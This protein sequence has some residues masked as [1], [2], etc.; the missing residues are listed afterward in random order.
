MYHALS[1]LKFGI[2]FWYVARLVYAR[3]QVKT[4]SGS[5]L[6][7]EENELETLPESL[8]LLQTTSKLENISEQLRW[9]PWNWKWRVGDAIR[10]QP[11]KLADKVDP[12]KSTEAKHSTI[13]AKHST[14]KHT[15][16]EEHPQVK[17]VTDLEHSVLKKKE[18]TEAG[19]AEEIIP[20]VKINS[21]QWNPHVECHLAEFGGLTHCRQH[22]DSL[23]NRL[24]SGEAPYKFETR[25]F[26]FASIEY[27]GSA[28]H[29][30]PPHQWAKLTH[31]CSENGD[32]DDVTL[33]YNTKLW[34]PLDFHRGGCMGPA[35]KRMGGFT[36]PFIAHAFNSTVHED[37]IV[38]VVGA[39]FD[40]PVHF[41]PARLRAAM[42][43]AVNQGFMKVLVIADTNFA[44]VPFADETL[45]ESSDLLEDIGAPEVSKT[46][47][48]TGMITCCKETKPI[49]WF[50]TGYDRIMAN[51]GTKMVTEMGLN[52]SAAND[53]AA[54]YMH[55][56]IV[57]SLHVS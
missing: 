2:V 37:M 22:M 12:I 26:D 21:L 18:T 24:L 42:S 35:D 39:H 51:F 8:L 47:S 20:E 36:K 6:P 55:L 38:L 33:L 9:K 25:S 32:G 31:D 44:T 15:P 16:E 3:E 45:R 17:K 50:K 41:N 19:P 28:R 23:I 40:H 7:Y 4:C 34:V 57:G 43:D 5:S 1:S 27:T 13:A 56:P 53:W 49:S 10:A 46:L 14:S 11:T 30:D 54:R 48:T 52:V 29:L